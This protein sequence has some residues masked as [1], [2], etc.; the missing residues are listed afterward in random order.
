MLAGIKLSPAFALV[1]RQS[2]SLARQETKPQSAPVAS[3]ESASERFPDAAIPGTGKAEAANV[4]LS[5]N[6][7]WMFGSK[8]QRGWAIYTPLIC[9]EIGTDADVATAEF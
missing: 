2:R 8:T 7:N 1:A 9:G 3:S 4:Q 6:L 5:T